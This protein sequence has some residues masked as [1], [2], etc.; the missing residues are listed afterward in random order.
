MHLQGRHDDLRD[1]FK[2]AVVGNQEAV[3]SDACVIVHVLLE[4][5]N[6]LDDRINEIP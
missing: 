2:A 5:L 3:G 6:K 1:N 4:I